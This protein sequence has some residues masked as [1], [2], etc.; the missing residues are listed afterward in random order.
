MN[1]LS[2]LILGLL[3]LLAAAGITLL[4]SALPDLDKGAW[5][6][7]A[8]KTIGGLLF[9]IVSAVAAFPIIS[10]SPRSSLTEDLG[11]VLLTGMA[12]LSLI[13]A[14]CMFITAIFQM[15]SALLTGGD[16]TS[17]GWTMML[18]G[19]IPGYLGLGAIIVLNSK[20]KK[21]LL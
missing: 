16:M 9:L 6:N 8:I 15:V 2:K 11:T 4:L 1:T 13:L 3:F 21:F 18:L 10:K 19:C 14:G 17:E 12:E 20:P 7:V 5:V